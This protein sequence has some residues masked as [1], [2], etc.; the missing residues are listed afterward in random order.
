MLSQASDYR[1]CSPIAA[2]IKGE[3]FPIRD[4]THEGHVVRYEDL[5]FLA[6]MY[7]ERLSWATRDDSEAHT[8]APYWF[9]NVLDRL[10]NPYSDLQNLLLFVGGQTYTGTLGSRI[11]NSTPGVIAADWTFANP[12]FVEYGDNTRQQ[13]FASMQPTLRCMTYLDDFADED[14]I[15]PSAARILPRPEEAN[16]LRMIYSDLADIKR[17][18]FPNHF[19]AGGAYTDFV[20]QANNG[21]YNSMDDALFGPVY[22]GTRTIVDGD[23]TQD[24]AEQSFAAPWRAEYYYRGNE[25]E[26]YL[27]HSEQ[28]MRFYIKSPYYLNTVQNPPAPYYTQPALY[29]RYAIAARWYGDTAND[30]SGRMSTYM[31]HP[32]YFTPTVNAVNL[33]PFEGEITIS[34]RDVGMELSMAYNAAKNWAQGELAGFQDNNWQLSVT[35]NEVYLDTGVITHNAII[36]A[37]P[38]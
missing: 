2:G 16:T 11:R 34:K 19:P 32:M 24:V 23:H 17:Y 8:V 31:V 29:A 9:S 22:Y 12:P 20:I 38:A 15:L 14:G 26:L 30:P 13:W 36:P 4:G 5:V 1:Y 35:L 33:G 3:P 21:F 28:Q 6:E 37:A 25:P 7:C 27:S 18:L 10:V